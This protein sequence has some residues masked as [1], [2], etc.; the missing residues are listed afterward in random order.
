[1]K[2][3]Q[4]F[5]K[6]NEVQD[7]KIDSVENEKSAKQLALKKKLK[8]KEENQETAKRLDR[9]DNLEREVENLKQIQNFVPKLKDL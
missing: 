2:S 7:D 5:M 9:I 4:Q 1:M 6:E 3:F 8:D